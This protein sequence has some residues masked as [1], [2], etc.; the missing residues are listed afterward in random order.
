MRSQSPFETS[1]PGDALLSSSISLE[2]SAVAVPGPI[3]AS[4]PRKGEIILLTTEHLCPSEVNGKT[5]CRAC[6]EKAAELLRRLGFI[7]GVR[8]VTAGVQA[9][10]AAVEAEIFLP[11][12]ESSSAIP[13]DGVGTLS[14]S[15]K[16]AIFDEA[17]FGLESMSASLY[18]KAVADREAEESVEEVMR[19]VEG[20]GLFLS[21]EGDGEGVAYD[22]TEGG[23]FDQRSGGFILLNVHNND[24]GGDGQAYLHMQELE[25]NEDGHQGDIEVCYTGSGF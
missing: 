9:V 21:D 5:R 19:R 23:E 6:Y 14:L 15:S 2:G 24:L 11:E 25:G 10:E 12:D 7:G 16:K 13:E 17:L 1:E 3:I 4:K 20:L 18:I 22:H 8:S